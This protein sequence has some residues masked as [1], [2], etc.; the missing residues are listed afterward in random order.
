M[1][2]RQVPCMGKCE[3]YTSEKAL[4]SLKVSILRPLVLQ[5]RAVLR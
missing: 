4:H 2:A 3:I 1:D 5:T